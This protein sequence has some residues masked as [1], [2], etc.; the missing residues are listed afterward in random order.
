[1]CAYNCSNLTDDDYA[2]AREVERLGGTVPKKEAKKVWC[3][4]LNA[5]LSGGMIST[6]AISAAE[7]ALEAY[8]EKFG[9]R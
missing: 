6:Y 1:M 8:K 9:N 2:E 7:D 4:A 5:A 3:D